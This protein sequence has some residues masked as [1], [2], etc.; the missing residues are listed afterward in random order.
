M[1]GYMYMR[2]YVC[3]RGWIDDRWVMHADMH[4]IW[5]DG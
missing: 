4:D 2:M 1:D 5:M 3:V